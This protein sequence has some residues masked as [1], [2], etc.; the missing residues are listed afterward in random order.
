MSGEIRRILAVDCGSTTTKAILIER[1]ADRYRLVGRGEAPTTV[2]APHEDVTRGVLDAAREIEER[3]GGSCSTADGRILTPRS[4]AT[5][6]TY[7]SRP[8][9]R[10]GG[11]QML[12]AGVVGV[13]DGRAAP[14]GP[15][16][17]PAPS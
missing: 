4:G 1:G 10:A 12:V 15:P 16:S 3:T 7:S 14:P 9:P 2:E 11:L 5:G 8:R 17:A 6:W 13:D